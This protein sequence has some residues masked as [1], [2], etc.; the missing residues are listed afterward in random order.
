MSYI[1]MMWLSTVWYQREAFNTIP[2]DWLQPCLEEITQILDPTTGFPKFGTC[3]DAIRGMGFVIRQFPRR[4]SPCLY[5]NTEDRL[6]S[7]VPNWRID[8]LE[9]DLLWVE[10]ILAFREG[11]YT[12]DERVVIAIETCD[13]RCIRGKTRASAYLRR[14]RGLMSFMDNSEREVFLKKWDCEWR[15]PRMV[16]GS[17]LARFDDGILFIPLPANNAEFD[18]SIRSLLVRI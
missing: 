7:I 3:T 14:L 12:I 2:S 4:V 9:F 13:C 6:E 15:T 1:V 18:Q 8:E 17:L 10:Y 11:F 16:V 5:L